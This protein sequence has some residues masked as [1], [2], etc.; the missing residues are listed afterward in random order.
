LIFII[1]QLK[2]DLE[3]SINGSG[4][5][6]HS[7]TELQIKTSRSKPTVGGSYIEL[8]D[9]IKN[10]KACVNIQNDDNKCFIW[11]LLAFFP[12]QYRCQGRM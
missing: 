8:P 1:N 7:I 2:K 6:L 9:V 4:F 11:C 3:S 10:K 5:I 12:S